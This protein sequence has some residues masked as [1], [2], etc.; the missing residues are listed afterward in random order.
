MVDQFVRR[1]LP[2]ISPPRFKTIQLL[3]P[4]RASSTGPV[5]VAEAVAVSS[6][7]LNLAQSNPTT[8]PPE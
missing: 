5:L 2:A 7:L 1:D 3:N 8:Q 4:S 6:E